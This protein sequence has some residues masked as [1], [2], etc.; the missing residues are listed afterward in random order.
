MRR[1]ST[2]YCMNPTMVEVRTMPCWRLQGV[3]R[4]DL[5]IWMRTRSE[6]ESNEFVGFTSNGPTTAL[7]TTSDLL[8]LDPSACLSGQS[9]PRLCLRS[10]SIYLFQLSS[11]QLFSRRILRSNEHPTA[12][13]SGVVILCCV[14]VYFCPLFS[15]VWQALVF[16]SSHYDVYHC[17]L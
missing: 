16:Y 15:A 10:P 8:S 3:Q 11:H 4:A 12:T 7:T 9:A 17:F 1:P 14:S 13:C 5:I 2:S 6:N